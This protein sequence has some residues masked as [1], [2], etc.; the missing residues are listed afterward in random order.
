MRADEVVRPGPADAA[1]V[2][3]AQ[4]DAIARVHGTRLY[5]GGVSV[6]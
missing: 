1:A 4:E 3:R 2:D 5:E 6:L